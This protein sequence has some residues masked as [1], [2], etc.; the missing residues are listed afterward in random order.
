MD[1][2][3][4]LFVQ[5]VKTVSDTVQGSE[6]VVAVQ[7]RPARPMT[8]RVCCTGNTQPAGTCALATLN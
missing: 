1:L 8:H 3:D 7:V 2:A 5:L 6:V 4:P